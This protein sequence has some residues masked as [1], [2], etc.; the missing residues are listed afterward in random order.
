MF[1][2]WWPPNVTNTFKLIL[3]AGEKLLKSLVRMQV[4]IIG[5][6]ERLKTNNCTISEFKK[7]I[8]WKHLNMEPETKMSE[9]KQR[10]NH[11]FSHLLTRNFYSFIF[12]PSLCVYRNIL[13]LCTVSAVG[14]DNGSSNINTTLQKVLSWWFPLSNGVGQRKLRKGNYLSRK[15][16]TKSNQSNATAPLNAS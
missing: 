12:F 14:H 3:C 1:V 5:R 15:R 2:C 8:A 4:F 13:Y 10:T 6:K 9:I 11:W 16:K 7:K